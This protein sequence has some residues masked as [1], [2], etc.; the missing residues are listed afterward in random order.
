MWPLHTG[1]LSMQ[2]ERPILGVIVYPVTYNY[3][4]E[5]IKN[6]ASDFNLS[7]I[8]N[9][10]CYTYY[11]KPTFSRKVGRAAGRV[12]KILKNDDIKRGFLIGYWSAE[13][14]IY[15]MFLL[16]IPLSMFTFITLILLAYGTYAFFDVVNP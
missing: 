1:G 6:I 14:V 15:L 2:K 3:V 7:H 12:V 16:I 10:N 8:F 5:D 13:M 11:E 9:N 4:L